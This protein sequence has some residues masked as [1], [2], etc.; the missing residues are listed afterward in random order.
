[1]RA[2]RKALLLPRNFLQLLLR[3]TACLCFTFLLLFRSAVRAH[4]NALLMQRSFWRV[5]LRDHVKYD[6]LEECLGQLSKAEVKAAAVYR[7]CATL[8]RLGLSTNIGCMRL[9]C[10]MFEG[11]LSATPAP[12]HC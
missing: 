11:C 12:P 6:E 10:C 3:L 1:V 4:R 2:H 5:L 9:C 7:R 8:T